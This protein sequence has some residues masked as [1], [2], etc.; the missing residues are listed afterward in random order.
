VNPQT[1]VIVLVALGALKQLAL[2]TKTTKDDL[3]AEIAERM[4]GVLLQGKMPVWTAITWALD[5][6]KFFAARSA[7][8]GDDK[9]VK[10]FADVTA[11][12][13]RVVGKEVY[14]PQYADPELVIDWPFLAAP[15]LPASAPGNGS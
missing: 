10:E 8:T 14:R 13:E 15:G 9:L 6:A 3:V 7:R 5:V 12:L 11:A 2:L 4:I 1:A